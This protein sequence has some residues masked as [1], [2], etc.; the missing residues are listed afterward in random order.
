MRRVVC[1]RALSLVAL[2][3]AL[4][5]ACFAPLAPSTE[6]SNAVCSKIVVGA[7]LSLTGEHSAG[8]IHLRN[9]YEYARKRLDEA[10][11]VPVR[12]RCHSLRIIYYDDE[13]SAGRAAQLTER[14]IVRDRVRFILGPYGLAKTAAVATVAA[15]HHVPVIA[16]SG[17]PQEL[18][19]GIDRSF[20]FPLVHAPSGILAA[21][22]DFVA[23]LAPDMARSPSDIRLALLF[24]TTRVDEGARAALRDRA[25]Q[26]GIE[27]IVD[28]V[29]GRD[30]GDLVQGLAKV[31]SERPEALLIDAHPGAANRALKQLREMQLDL[32]VLAMAD[33]ADARLIARNREKAENVLCISS[34]RPPIGA[35]DGLFGSAESFTRDYAAHASSEGSKTESEGVAA[36]AA[37]AAVAVRV[38]AAAIVRANS[39]DHFQIRDALAETDLDTI[40]GRV[41][42]GKQ[43][44]GIHVKP[45]I[46]QVMD[47]KYVTVWP[48][49][50]A[51]G[52]Y[53]WPGTAPRPF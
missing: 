23:R 5:A 9:G 49:A 25:R 53:R 38:L 13:S 24:D 26:L 37:Q 29:F 27:I 43:S 42:F 32:P 40:I 10:G 16:V 45:V 3:A 22:P 20:F 31:K 6:A 21:L 51:A 17:L 11:G 12:G 8:G 1:K 4:F 14:L 41:S 47:G 39:L 28:Q 34:W 48:K 33:C 36:S 50:R 18:E 7:V 35:H 19:A 2:A 15:R 44:D 52:V 30:T 46:R